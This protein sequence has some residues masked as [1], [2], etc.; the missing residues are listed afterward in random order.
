MLGKYFND[1]E[2]N[3]VNKNKLKQFR[4][5]FEIIKNVDGHMKHVDTKGKVTK[6]TN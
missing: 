6:T 4:H 1:N 2:L 5:L 3:R